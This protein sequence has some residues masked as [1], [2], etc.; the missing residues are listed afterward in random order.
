[1]CCCGISAGKAKR[2][3]DWLGD[4][5][6]GGPKV[7]ALLPDAD[8]AGE[9][10][11][12]GA[13]GLLLRSSGPD[14]LVAA[15]RAAAEG[16]ITLDPALSSALPSA[17]PAVPVEELT[18]RESEVLHLLAEGLTNKAIARRLDISDH[19]VKFHIN[20]ILSKLHAQS[21]TEAVVIGLRLGLISL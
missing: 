11:T 10:W 9:L 12:A 5:G 3:P 17:S 8:S 6:E 14:R 1:M 19:T 20:A 13:R 18:H 2:L 16:L 4:L 15:I 7:V 21:R